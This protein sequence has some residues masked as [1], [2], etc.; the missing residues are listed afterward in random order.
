MKNAIVILANNMRFFKL[1]VQNFPSDI[2]DYEVIVVNE[3]RIGD[4]TT[5]ICEILDESICNRFR[6]F[7]SSL[8]LEK[9][10]ANVVDNSFVDSYT[11]SMN[12]L[13][14]WFVCKY[15]RGIEKI[16]LVD[17]D[18]IINEGLDRLFAFDQHVFK[19]YRLSAGPADFYSQ[20]AKALEV[21]DE[22]FRIFNIEFTEDWWKEVYLRRY[23]SSGQRLIVRNKLDLAKYEQ[24]LKEFFESEILE[25][26]WAERRTHTSGFFDEKFET[27]FFLEE[28]NDIM[29]D[30][31][32]IVVSKPE[33]LT[34][35]DYRRMQ[36]M[37][38]VHNATRS[39]KDVVY[40]EMI[41]RK[42]IVGDEV[43]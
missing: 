3:T 36:R 6:V 27:L 41:R 22:W 14:L 39:H 38:I 17:E 26:T 16:L 10:K 19:T 34:D 9:F 21:W 18:V 13:S 5:E 7:P 30:Y 4:K 2:N 20:S 29:K 12:I 33:K 40:N 1:L 42:I 32:Y 8:I 15:N 11:M 35:G 31:V 43:W 24:K 28:E 37:V 25:M 23:E